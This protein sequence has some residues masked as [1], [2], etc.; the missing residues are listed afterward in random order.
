MPLSSR[1]QSGGK[2]VPF[3]TPEFIQG[4]L[5]FPLYPFCPLIPGQELERM[6][7]KFGQVW[8]KAE[9][10][11]Q[12]RLVTLVAQ[13]ESRSGGCVTSDG[14]YRL[15]KRL[16]QLEGE[17]QEQKG[18][19]KRIIRKKGVCVCMYVYMSVYMCMYVCVYEYVYGLCMCV[20]VYVFVC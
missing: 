18:G 16:I 20:Y 6:E 2:V 4:S 7:E 11:K 19:K 9:P 12:Q 15:G 3:P 8:K 14:P 5:S 17:V 10:T 13:A 1:K